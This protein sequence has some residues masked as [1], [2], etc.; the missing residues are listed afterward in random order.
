[1]NVQ[2]ICH[3]FVQH[4]DDVDGVFVQKSVLVLSIHSACELP[5][6]IVD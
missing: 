6:A 1:M 3:L 5:V 2:T 4:D